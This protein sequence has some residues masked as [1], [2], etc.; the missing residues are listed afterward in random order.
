L[1]LEINDSSPSNSA[2]SFAS[3]APFQD[4]L[5]ASPPEGDSPPPQRWLRSLRKPKRAHMLFGTDLDDLF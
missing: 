2:P 4:A 5:A 3:S 1:G